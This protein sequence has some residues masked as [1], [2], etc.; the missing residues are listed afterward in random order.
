MRCTSIP[1]EARREALE[2]TNQGENITYSKAK[3]IVSQYS[4]SIQPK[5]STDEP[6][7]IA[8]SSETI[9]TEESLFLQDKH[10]VF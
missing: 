7:P 4:E 1:Q 10:N 9:P 5:I 3:T 8:Q 2:L 6:A